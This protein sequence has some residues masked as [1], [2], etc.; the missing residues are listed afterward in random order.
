M[1]WNKKFFVRIKKF[2]VKFWHPSDLSL[3]LC[4]LHKN[5]LMKLSLSWVSKV[6]LIVNLFLFNTFI[7]HSWFLVISDLPERKKSHTFENLILT[8]KLF[9]I[10][11]SKGMWKM[12]YH[13][14]LQILYFIYMQ[15]QEKILSVWLPKVFQSEQ[16]CLS[17]HL[18]WY[19]DWNCFHK[20]SS[21][22]SDHF[23]Q[24]LPKKFSTYSL[25]ENASMWV[26]RM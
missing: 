2:Q 26:H 24:A 17:L 11:V 9:A 14:Q 1:F 4:H 5:W 18:F 13:E 21:D 16:I 3:W 23:G 15:W 20:V 8:D 10:M 25:A 6:S 12:D 19:S 22:G 7:R